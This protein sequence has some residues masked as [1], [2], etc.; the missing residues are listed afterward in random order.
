MDRETL[1]TN[2]FNP[3]HLPNFSV[4]Y[5][6]TFFVSYAVHFLCPLPRCRRERPVRNVLALRPSPEQAPFPWPSVLHPRF[7]FVDVV[8][9]PTC[10]GM[11]YLSPKPVPTRHLRRCVVFREPDRRKLALRLSPEQLLF[12]CPSNWFPSVNKTDLTE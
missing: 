10:G 11:T 3:C 12:T 2:L 9:E 7:F 6:P 5:S 4:S 8:W 1:K